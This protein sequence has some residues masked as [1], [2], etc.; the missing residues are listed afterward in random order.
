VTVLLD[1]GKD[2]AAHGAP[3]AATAFLRRA[4]AEPPAADRRR[5]VLRH[6]G[7][8]EVLA[9]LPEAVVHL[10]AALE[11]AE[12]LTERIELTFDLSR[13]LLAVD[14]EVEG[15]Q[16]LIDLLPELGDDAEAMML[17]E[18]AIASGAGISTA[19]APLARP[20]LERLLDRVAR[21]GAQAGAVPLENRTAALM[22]QLGANP[23]AAAVGDLAA[24]VVDAWRVESPD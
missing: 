2:F 9:G 17:V 22:A 14:E 6:L 7:Q 24:S 15:T 1:V 13:A 23:P 8:A 10:R 20:Y 18:G 11:G 12:T 16:V 5:D 4:L 3:D 19:M 21:T